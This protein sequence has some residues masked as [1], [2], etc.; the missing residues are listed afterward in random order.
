MEAYFIGKLHVINN[1]S[2]C[3][4]IAIYN[5]TNVSDVLSSLKLSYDFANNKTSNLLMIPLIITNQSDLRSIERM[6][7]GKLVKETT[8]ISSIF[9]LRN[10][11][12]PVFLD[13][14]SLWY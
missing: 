1:C 4:Q 2:G 13:Q 10:R 9:F 14:S 7:Q 11:Y 12:K 5:Y 3:N 8:Q 6:V